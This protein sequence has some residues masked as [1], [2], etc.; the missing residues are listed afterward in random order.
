MQI[1]A[2]RRGSLL[3]LI[4]LSTALF[5]VACSGPSA[6]NGS[7][8]APDQEPT[9][10]GTFTAN[11]FVDEPYSF[12]VSV[13]DP[14][15]SPLTY[16]WQYRSYP[17]GFDPTGAGQ[18]IQNANQPDATFLPNV[19]GTYEIDL[20]VS[21][22]QNTVTFLFTIEISNQPLP[23]A[24][25]PV[26]PQDGAT[27]VQVP[28][29][30]DWEDPD[31]SLTT[32]YRV[33]LRPQGGSSWTLVAWQ[34]TDGSETLNAGDTD[35]DTTYEWR[36]RSSGPGGGTTSP[37]YTFTTEAGD[38]QAGLVAEWRMDS[39]NS[40]VLDSSGNGNHGSLWPGWTC[41]P[42]NLSFQCPTPALPTT[43]RAGDDN[44]A[45]QFDGVND[46]FRVPYPVPNS[47][48]MAD[49]S[50]GFGLS[51]WI[52]P[53]DD[54]PAGVTLYS[55]SDGQSGIE[56]RTF[57]EQNGT[58]MRIVVA[59]L[60]R[61]GIPV[62]SLT[63]NAWNHIAFTWLPQDG[64]VIPYVNG[65]RGTISSTT[66]GSGVNSDAPVIIAWDGVG[67]N[68]FVGGMD[69]IRVYARSLRAAD[70]WALFNE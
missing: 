29:T 50:N 8:G 15:G 13:S 41:D 56:I 1:K 26:S 49:F 24:S 65:V 52:R 32:S 22:G 35:F 60:G 48:P 45:L 42:F 57:N 63:N 18:Q 28:V 6:G 31:P 17:P 34:D 47:F 27:G 54:I 44:A 9:A 64:H 70:V 3:P 20:I 62:S 16:Q 30:L 68:Y 58:V 61:A 53:S 5:V 7:G 21:D 66:I 46:Y 36:I 14:E 51:L 37:I 39:A 67:Q 33:D 25:I 11:G 23:I 12:D 10:T 59:G 2:V 55:K 4:A 43:D 69:D 38:I 19:V 40:Y